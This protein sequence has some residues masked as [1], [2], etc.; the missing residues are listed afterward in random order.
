MS[1]RETT[2]QL[3]HLECAGCAHLGEMRK[4]V[5]GHKAYVCLAPVAD[6]HEFVYETSPHSQC[7]LWVP[8]EEKPK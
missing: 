5:G 4:L 8:R 3:P 6:G 2:T 1:T 7:E